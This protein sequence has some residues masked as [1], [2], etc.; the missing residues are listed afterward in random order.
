MLAIKPFFQHDLPAVSDERHGART[1]VLG[2]GLRAPDP[3][4]L[5]QSRVHHVPDARHLASFPAQPLPAE[6]AQLLPGFQRAPAA[7]LHSD[8]GRG[9]QRGLH[10]R[11]GG[12]AGAAGRDQRL[13]EQAEA[14]VHQDLHQSL[15]PPA[16]RQTAGAESPESHRD[17]PRHGHALQALLGPVPTRLE[18]QAAGFRQ[19]SFPR[20]R[21]P[22]GVH[23]QWHG[24][25]DRRAD[26]GLSF[27]PKA[28]LRL[29]DDQKADVDLN[30]ELK[31][32][33]K[34]NVDLN[35]K[36][37]S[38]LGLKRWTESWSWLKREMLSCFRLEWWTESW[39]RLK[40]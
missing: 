38:G 36:L 22:R 13:R 37:K 9:A 7:R 10:R 35:D 23:E 33:Q 4:P 40:W 6:P 17:G 16:H 27:G 39:S 24:Q 19:S 21:R 1:P 20:G 11:A 25:D 3:G 18:R 29:S 8:E 26:L 31:S 30:D 32:G 2:P 12:A 28:G 15:H 34:T 5:L 14:R